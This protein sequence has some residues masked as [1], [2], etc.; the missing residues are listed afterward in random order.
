MNSAN[1]RFFLTGKD[2]WEAMFHACSVAKKSIDLE[3]YIITDD[4]ISTRL[5]E[6][7]R[8]RARSGVK[9]RVLVDTV[10]SWNLYTS[11]FPKI[12]RRDG[13][14]VRFFNIVSPWRITNFSSWFFRDHRKILVVDK[15]VGF[16]GGV[17]I[18]DDMTNWRDTH[19]EVRGPI[20]KEMEYAFDDLWN[21]SAER[22]LLVRLRKARFYTRGF[23]FFTNAPYFRKRFLY[24]AIIEAIRSA[25]KYIYLT[26]PYF[27][28]DGRLQRVLKLAHKRGIDVQII[29][30]KLSNMPFVERA[31]HSHFEPLLESGVKIFEYDKNTFLHAKTA[32]IDDEWATVGSFNLDSM[33]FLYNYEANIVSTD[34][35]FVEALKSHFLED[36]KHSKQVTL[37]EWIRRPLLSKLREILVM[38]IRRFL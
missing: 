34:N 5:I 19:V 28:P 26:T 21:Q 3:Q 12:M 22:D 31:A 14:E 33:S 36:L 15:E 27:V 23:H 18:R 37:E 4:R 25:K 20:V 9:V 1:W 16:T 35:V 29:V 38:P 13:I 32:V 11:P 7:L 24:H 17:G 10:G 6:I 2:A 30:P 8:E